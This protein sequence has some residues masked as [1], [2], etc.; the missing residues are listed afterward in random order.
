MIQNTEMDLKIMLGIKG[1]AGKP[2]APLPETTRE[3]QAI[4]LALLQ[5]IEK[6]D[7]RL[8]FLEELIAGPEK[9]K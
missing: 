8:S 4:T 7:K 3:V 5:E 6:L 9:K 2:S 1:D